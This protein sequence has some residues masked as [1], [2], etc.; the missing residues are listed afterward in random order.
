MADYYP[1]IS[2]AVASLERNDFENRKALYERARVALLA[3]LRGMTPD[4]SESDITRQ[5]LALEEAIRRVEEDS[6]RR[7]EEE[8]RAKEGVLRREEEEFSRPAAVPSDVA[9]AS[10][11]PASPVPKLYPDPIER[12]ESQASTS[13]PARRSGPIFQA[14]QLPLPAEL[15]SQRKESGM[16][17][18]AHRLDTERHR[19]L[20]DT[21]APSPEDQ[22]RA[23]PVEQEPNALPPSPPRASIEANREGPPMPARVGRK[24]AV[25]VARAEI[26]R[27]PRDPVEFGVSHPN[28]VVYAAPFVMD[29]W[30]YRQTD[31]DEVVR[32]AQ[33]VR[34]GMR[35]DSGG[36]ATIAR[37]TKVIV[38]LEI[39][40][41]DVDPLHQTIVWTGKITNVQFAVS[42]IH[43]V[44]GGK[45]I[46][47]CS[48][49][50]R[51]LLVGQVVFELPLG[52]AAQDETRLVP[53]RMIRSAFASYASG[54][55]K[56]VIARVQGMEKLGV[57]VFVD[58]R[59]L[60][61]GDQYPTYLLE[62]IDSSDVLYLF[63]SHHA[64]HSVWV[65]KEWRYGLERNGIEFIDP[66]P[67]VDP[68]KVAPPAELADRMHFQRLDARFF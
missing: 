58:V 1:L 41:W 2:R 42:P 26:S 28:R 49:F 50:V 47:K 62:K 67:L 51:G 22:P 56:A 54:D 3:Q 32:R 55:R 53:A 45:A 43:D 40:A 24:E 10:M 66:V 18:V 17:D 35:F 44:A 13:A 57:Q 59:Y 63:W 14:D 23:A 33:S 16:K 48:F 9:E 19:A 25:T 20:R 15:R 12:R 61:A 37:G 30:I 38:R 5:Q 46:G 29:A 6:I 60:K 7:V 39:E 31:R 64:K 36:S 21:D 4:L 8:R 27:A 68:R 34:E 52:A 65:E 11:R